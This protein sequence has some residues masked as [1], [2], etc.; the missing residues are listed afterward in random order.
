L[1]LVQ[2]PFSVVWI[3]WCAS[4][5]ITGCGEGG[6]GWWRSYDYGHQFVNCRNRI[7]PAQRAD[8]GNY[9]LTHR[10]EQAQFATPAAVRESFTTT[11][12]TPPPYTLADKAKLRAANFGA[13]TN[14][15]TS[16]TCIALPDCELVRGAFHLRPISEWPW[17]SNKRSWVGCVW[18]AQVVHHPILPVWL[19]CR[20]MAYIFRPTPTTLAV[21]LIERRDCN[22]GAAKVQRADMPALAARLF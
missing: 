17:A 19:T 8:A 2:G 6:S 16:S 21:A 1:S 11:L 7:G 18:G 15:V 22:G 12:T 3:V 4:K 13:V 14:W 10:T 9:L 20:E 5:H